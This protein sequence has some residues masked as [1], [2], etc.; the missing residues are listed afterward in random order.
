MD[1]FCRVPFRL[2]PIFQSAFC[3]VI[4]STGWDS[5]TLSSVEMAATG[6]PVVAS[7]LQGLAEAVVDGQTG[8]LFEAGNAS[9]LADALEALLDDPA[10]AHAYGLAG[11]RRSEL[12]LSL[13]RQQERFAAALRRRLGSPHQTAGATAARSAEPGTSAL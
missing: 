9:A 4:P 13:K 5:F 6:L 7:R 11:R 2:L 1:P 12:E 8:L 3:G 10:R